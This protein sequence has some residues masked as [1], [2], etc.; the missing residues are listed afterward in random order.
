VL[1]T[2]RNPDW[3]VC[4]TPLSVDAFTRN[5]SRA[6]LGAHIASLDESDAD[7][8]AEALEDLPLALAQASS[9]LTGGLSAAD[10][11]SEL[12]ANTAAVLAA[13]Q[14][15]GYPVSLAAQVR[16]NTDRLA[17]EQPGALALLS[18]L[19][20][21]APEPFPV[22][23]CA[24]RLPHQASGALAEALASRLTAVP[25]LQAIARHSLAR[26]QSG[27]VQL[28]RLTQAV[29]AD[30]LAPSQRVQ[31]ARDAEALLAAAAPGNASD[32][33]GWPVW[34]VL[35]PHLLAGPGLPHHHRRT[36]CAAWRVL[37]PD[38]PRPAPPRPRAS[39]APV[40][41]LVAAAGPRPRRH[42]ESRPHPGP[43][44]QRHPGS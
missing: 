44:L 3:Q 39:A 27:T 13:G 31:A 30:Q 33:V 26:T 12:A 29:L 34:Q 23:A 7:D 17:A 10:L 4:A 20:L 42:P 41:H 25:M 15:A 16:A 38:G 2:S 40:R 9:L 5:E 32:P 22:T 14:P 6:L 1:I 18:A 28:H 36:V 19:A 43:R 35:L 21:L 37:V 24:G 11:K 8:L